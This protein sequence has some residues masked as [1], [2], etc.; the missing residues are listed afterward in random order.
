MSG[1]DPD[2]MIRPYLL[3]GG[4]TQPVGEL[5]IEALVETTDVGDALPGRP[6]QHE[7]RRVLEVC[8]VPNSVAEVAAA[9]SIPLGVARVLIADLAADGRLRVHATVADSGPDTH[10]LE[11]LLDGLRS[12]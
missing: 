3:T 9:L 6:L 1:P 2:R 7:P 4:R 10:L 11:R 5:P 8:R 12:C